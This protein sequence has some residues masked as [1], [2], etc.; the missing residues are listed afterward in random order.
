MPNR[1]IQD[2]AGSRR[3][4]GPLTGLLDLLSSIWFGVGVLTAIF[5]YSSIGSAV[6]PIRQG[7]LADWLGWEALRFE[8]TEMEWF[9]SPV[10]VAM[11]VLFCLSMI[12]A[13]LRR[14]RLSLPN[15]GV[16][17]IHTGIVV[18]VVGCVIYFGR[19][20]EGDTVIYQRRAVIR[21]PGVEQPATMV[22]R[23]DAAVRLGNGDE[24]Y[25]VSV[26][27]MQPRYE[28]L[29]GPDKGRRTTA[30]W[31]NVQRNREPRQ[32]ARVVLMGYPEYTEDVILGGPQGMQRAVKTVGRRLLDE[33]LR[34]DLE[35]EPAT[36]YF[37]DHTAALYARTDPDGPWIEMPIRKLPRYYDYVPDRSE[38]ASGGDVPPA[39]RPL[40]LPIGPEE[41]GTNGLSGLR[42]RA[43]GFLSYARLESRWA[44]GGSQLYPVLR[45][46]LAGTGERHSFELVAMDPER[47]RIGS[48]DLS[49]PIVFAWV[50]SEAERE[51]LFAPH[52]PRLAFTPPGRTE[53]IEVRLG[54]VLDRGPQPLPGTDYTIEVRSSEVL[55]DFLLMSAGLRGRRDSLVAVRVQRGSLRYRRLV[56]AEHNEHSRDINEVHEPLPQMVEPDMKI[57]FLD[58]A[59]VGLWLV[60]GPGEQDCEIVLARLDGS[61]ARRKT[62]V[63]EPVELEKGAPPIVVE[64]LISHAVRVERPVV[65][66]PRE[67]E[68][69]AGSN[70]SMLR[71]EVQDGD[72][73]QG[74]WL[75][76]NP[77]PFPSGAYAYPQRF[78][79]YGSYAP[80]TLSLS[81]GRRIE[82]L[83]SRQRR[84]L[85]APIAL[86]R[87]VLETH[88]GGQRER[89]FISVVRYGQGGAWSEPREIRSNQPAQYGGLWFFQAEW[90]PAA[91]AVTV[92]GV[93]NREGI[94]TMLAGV[95]L[96]ILGMIYAFYVKPVL[97]RRG[98]RRVAG[99]PP[100]RPTPAAR[101]A[102]GVAEGQVHA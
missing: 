25:D 29:S 95:V 58:P 15:L 37:L 43:T 67:R 92:L 62:R 101:D 86:E 2:P 45:F 69:G 19:K 52:E 60:G 11:V 44:G 82:L 10:F 39:V 80:R 56:Y 74:V 91:E 97:L 78:P 99:A 1:S 96:S 55:S 68:P 76:F 102:T 8:M 57:R 75:P 4:R 65:V 50:R 72:G 85:P 23:P 90:D 81:G 53:T 98:T 87:F 7:A 35:Y 73:V 71:V 100:G 70:A 93:G 49:F 38:V 33:D 14:A 61:L 84:A 26:Y 32:F 5:L 24:T 16:W 47:H 77:Y 22:V 89:D 13:T 40:D 3:R 94:G 48:G 20:I 9:S 54:D 59:P 30:V 36:E 27:S 42:F 66:P 51:K 18:L 64:S 46:S 6:P 17:I 63:G 83:Y 34:I 88:P 41:G 79:P 28:I 21:V 31:F 12:L